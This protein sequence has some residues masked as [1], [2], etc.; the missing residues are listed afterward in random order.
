[1][2]VLVQDHVATVSSTLQ[3]VNEEERPL[4]ALFVFPLPADAAVC[5]FSAKIGEQE[6]VAEVQERQSVSPNTNHRRFPYLYYTSPFN[7]TVS[8]RRGISMMML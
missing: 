1:M 3:Y 6:I 4:E 8:C 7:K 5:H 2:E